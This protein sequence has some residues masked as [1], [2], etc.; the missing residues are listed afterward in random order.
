MIKSRW[1]ILIALLGLSHN[2]LAAEHYQFIPVNYNIYPVETSIDAKFNVNLTY[3]AIDQTERHTGHYGLGLDFS[4]ILYINDL[5]GFGYSFGLNANDQSS[6]AT[7]SGQLITSSLYDVNLLGH[8]QLKFSDT[9]GLRLSLGLSYVFGWVNNYRT[10]YY[11]RFEPVTGI[12]FNY[13]L[14]R[15]FHLF[16]G[17]FHYFGVSKTSAFD[18]STSAPSINRFSIGGRYVF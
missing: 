6:F 7:R 10:S 2:L 1:L 11:G 12:S 16:T 9:F 8:Y 17:Y 4:Q 13:Q 5:N 14:N 15:H 18:S 3:A